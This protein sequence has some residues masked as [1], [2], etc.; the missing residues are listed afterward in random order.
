MYSGSGWQ[1]AQPNRWLKNNA[2]PRSAAALNL[3][4]TRYGLGSGC[5]DSSDEKAWYACVAEQARLLE[6]KGKVRILG[7]SPLFLSYGAV[8]DAMAA[9]ADILATK[10][11]DQPQFHARA[12]VT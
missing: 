8:W 3:P 4:S 2:L 11:W 5:S 7:F 1:L 6:E 9:L 10:S 12:K